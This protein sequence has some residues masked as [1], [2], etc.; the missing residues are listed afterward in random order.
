MPRKVA[1]AAGAA[2]AAVLPWVVGVAPVA[3]A[4]DEEATVLWDF[5]RTNGSGVTCSLGARATLQD[6]GDLG[7][8]ARIEFTLRDDEPACQNPF[9]VVRLTFRDVHG[10]IQSVEARGVGSSIEVEARNVIGTEE[11]DVVG[12]VFVSYSGPGCDPSDCTTS[13]E[14]T[15]K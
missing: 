5:T 10:N 11:D 3:A 6:H 4:S 2:G 8:W 9:V 7:R 12:K 15:P 13:R 1:M 14:L